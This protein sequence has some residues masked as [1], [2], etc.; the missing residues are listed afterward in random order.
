MRPARAARAVHAS[1][2]HLLE[3][4]AVEEDA[5]PRRID[6]DAG[7]PDVARHTRM[8]RVVAAVRGQVERHR[9]A[10]LAGRE[11]RAV[12]GI[13]FLGRRE[14]GV[15]ADRPGA[16]RVHRGAGSAQ[17]R[18]QARQ[19]VGERQPFEVGGR[20]E[21]LDAQAVGVSRSERARVAVAQVLA[22]EL[23]PLSQ[24]SAMR[25]GSSKTR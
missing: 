22:R 13:R 19:R 3:R 4:D 25:S 11:V 16:I 10:L 5:C 1:T 7:L 17:E 14:A 15:L 21:R 23:A 18:E 8:I 20:V 6:R 24:V 9:E 2:R 12:E